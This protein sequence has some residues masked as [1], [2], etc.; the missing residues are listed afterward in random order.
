MNIGETNTYS[1]TDYNRN[2]V[3]FGSTNNVIMIIDS[4]MSFFNNS[5]QVINFNS[6]NKIT[7]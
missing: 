3:Y 7:I 5:Y 2:I 6:L 4:S 1:T